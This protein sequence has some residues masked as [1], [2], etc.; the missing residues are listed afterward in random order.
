MGDL[1][2]MCNQQKAEYANIE[3]CIIGAVENDDFYDHIHD[4]FSNFDVDRAYYGEWE[5]NEMQIDSIEAELAYVEFVDNR[6]LAHI[7]VVLWVLAE[8]THRDEEK[9]QHRNS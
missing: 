6:C 9:P 1:I 8:I 2:K 3:A 5:C 4:H 7:D